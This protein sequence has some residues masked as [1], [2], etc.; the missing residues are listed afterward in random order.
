MLGKTQK[1][2]SSLATVNMATEVYVAQAHSELTSYVFPSFRIFS[3]TF[4]SVSATW[5]VSRRL[6]HRRLVPRPL[7]PQ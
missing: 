1:V 3:S 4:F 7:V 5:V 2:N 6:V